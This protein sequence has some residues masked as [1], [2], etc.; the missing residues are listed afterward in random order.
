[1]PD[2]MPIPDQ[3]HLAFSWR[4]LPET[5]VRIQHPMLR[6]PLSLIID[7]P[8]PGYNPAYFHSGFRNG[9]ERI[10]VSLVDDFADLVERTGLRGKFSIVPYPFGLGRVDRE[11]EG[12]SDADRRYFLDVV[13]ARIAPFL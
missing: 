11:I 3:E 13:R 7:D 1:M 10:P 4:D 9:P 5:G 12:V 2:P 8:T 6:Q